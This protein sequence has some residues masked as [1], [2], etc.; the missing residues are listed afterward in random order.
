MDALK[1]LEET[2]KK[3]KKIDWKAVSQRKRTELL[4]FAKVAESAERYMDMCRFTKAIVEASDDKEPLKMQERNLLSVAY[5]NVVGAL[6]QAWRGVSSNNIEN[7]SEE[8]TAKYKSYIEKQ[9][10]VVCNEVLK[11]LQDKPLAKF[12]EDPEKQIAAIDKDKMAKAPQKDKE[13]YEEQVF[14]LKMCGDYYRYLSEFSNDAGNKE[15]TEKYYGYATDLAEKILAETHPTRLGLALN[16][17]VCY[18]EILKK[19]AEASALAKKAFDAAIEKLDTLND[20]SYKD[21]TLIMQLL[22]D[23]LT[24]WS[25]ENEE[26][27][28]DPE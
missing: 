25:S 14:F 10:N 23:N 20:E 27:P 16:F 9:L 18:F 21:S 19:K 24:L 17:S 6:R 15:N 3:N 28:A 11:V 12:L 13:P 1:G 7:A 5:K 2:L 8:Q 22:R 4:E 26:A